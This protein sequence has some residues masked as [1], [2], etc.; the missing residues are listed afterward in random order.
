MVLTDPAIQGAFVTVHAS[1]EGQLTE[2]WYCPR[3]VFTWPDGTRSEIESDCPAWPPEAGFR[4]TWSRSKFF[5]EG[6]WDVVVSLERA[7]KVI[8]REP[9]RIR[10]KG[11]ADAPEF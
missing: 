8:A 10:V 4:Q 5:G 1:I 3:V 2:D 7:G 9:V 11:G 6:E